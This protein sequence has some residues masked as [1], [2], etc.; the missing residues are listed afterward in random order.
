MKEKPS[1]SPRDLVL[2]LLICSPVTE[3]GAAVSSPWLDPTSAAAAAAAA[4]HAAAVSAAANQSTGS[5]SAAAAAAAAA[6]NSAAGSSSSNNNGAG[7]SLNP[8]QA[9]YGADYLGR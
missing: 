8:E 1:L 6:A 5:P 4:Q 9:T 7:H 3:G 2:T